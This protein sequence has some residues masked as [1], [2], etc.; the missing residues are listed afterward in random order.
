ML[1]VLA[2]VSAIVIGHSGDGSPCTFAQSRQIAPF[3]PRS[4]TI[5]N[6]DGID[7]PGAV[8]ESRR[9]GFGGGAKETRPRPPAVDDENSAYYC[10]MPAG[11]A[12]MDSHLSRMATTPRAGSGKRASQRSRC[13]CRPDDPH[14]TGESRGDACCSRAHLLHEL[15]SAPIAVQ[16]VGRTAA[17][18]PSM[19][20]AERLALWIVA[21]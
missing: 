18:S 17:M 6:V 9:R 11:E 19:A 5:D 10:A 13:A 15:K 20:V 14:G 4:E 8:H 1:V 3:Q 16:A 7:L 12:T 2:Q 21:S